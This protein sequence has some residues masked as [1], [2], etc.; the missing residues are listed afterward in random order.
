MSKRISQKRMSELIIYK[1][2]DIQL[3]I[4][5][6]LH[7]LKKLPLHE[8]HF[9]DKDVFF[10]FTSRGCIQKAKIFIDDKIKNLEKELKLTKE[11][12]SKLVELFNNTEPG[13]KDK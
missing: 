5:Y 12:K 6:M 2:G 10:A 9:S 8:T 7:A 11:I 4:V 1:S 3:Q 13:Q